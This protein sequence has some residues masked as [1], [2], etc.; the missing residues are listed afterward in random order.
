MEVLEG[1]CQSLLGPPQ[2]HSIPFFFSFLSLSEPLRLIIIS[3]SS[4]D[5]EGGGIFY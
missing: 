5:E 4:F 3:S 1:K 2:K